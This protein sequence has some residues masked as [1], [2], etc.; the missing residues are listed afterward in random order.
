MKKNPYEV[1]GVPYNAS[2]EEIKKAYKKKIRACHPDLF[3]DNPA[4]LEKAKEINDAYD[5]L[6]KKRNKE[7]TSINLDQRKKEAIFQIINLKYISSELKR[8]YVSVI[9][10][11]NL[12]T[13]IEETLRKAFAM[14]KQE[15]EKKRLQ[16]YKRKIWEKICALQ[17]IYADKYRVL[18]SNCHTVNDM[19][20]VYELA[21]KEH[22]KLFFKN[23]LKEKIKSIESLLY[24]LN[25]DKEGY[26]EQLKLCQEM[27]DID[28]IIAVA[29]CQENA[30]KKVIEA[31]K[32]ELKKSLLLKY[33]LSVEQ[34]QMAFKQIDCCY[35]VNAIE[36][37]E[38]ELVEF[39]DIYFILVKLP[40]KLQLEELTK[41]VSSNKI[42]AFT[43]KQLIVCFM[44]DEIR[45]TRNLMNYNKRLF[46]EE[47][48]LNNNIEVLDK[49]ENIN[50]E[51]K[52]YKKMNYN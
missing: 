28:R 14:E 9:D 20:K 5:I 30:L 39:F 50:I 40:K 8:L 42:S 52:L 23:F 18:L 43:K 46:C 26:I 6:I 12:V 11:T 1:L 19:D 31:K 24:V 38:K 10:R 17:Y 16:E 25:S 21:Q 13:E 4:A 22:E 36:T 7:N 37:V 3:P 49:I 51:K 41:I 15:E 44:Q 32:E 35:T 47:A 34:R 45:Q 48:L 2:E 29:M 27:V 33:N